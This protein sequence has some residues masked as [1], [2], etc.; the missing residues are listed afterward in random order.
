MV[1]SKWILILNSGFA[2]STHFASTLGCCEQT[3]FK[4]LV[5]DCSEKVALCRPTPGQKVGVEVEEQI[6]PPSTNTSNMTAAT[7]GQRGPCKNVHTEHVPTLLLCTIC[8][9]PVQ[10][11]TKIFSAT[12]IT[13]ESGI[14]SVLSPTPKNLKLWGLPSS[15]DLSS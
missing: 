4:Y 2:P 8:N 12:C 1:E 9:S 13:M 7:T 11:A 3:T 15:R 10:P 5:S 6:P 14:K